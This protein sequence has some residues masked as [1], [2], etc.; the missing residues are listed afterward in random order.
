[1]TKIN[2]KCEEYHKNLLGDEFETFLEWVSREPKRSIRVNPLKT[3]IEDFSEELKNLNATPIPWCPTGFWVEG[4]GIGASIPHLFGYFYIQEAASM[5]PPLVLDVE[6]KDCVLDMCAAPGSKTTQMAPFCDTIIAN[7]PDISRSKAL[8]ANVERCGVMNA[9]ITHFDGL[10]FPQHEIF[11]KVL[12]DVPCSNMGSSRK[13]SHVLRTWT[14][15]FARNIS[16]LQKGLLR[17]AYGTLKSGGTLVYSTCTSSLE[18]NEEVVL[19]LLEKEDNAKLEVIDK[20]KLN[21]ETREGLLPGSENA[22]RIY[23]WDNNTEFFFVAK[24]KK[25]G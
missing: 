18:E 1:M 20:K 21:M 24:I 22:I 17:K 23:P 2:K 25:D 12:V 15:G 13:N 9:C 14:P 5:V 3:S 16:G 4:K 6:E 10:R 8:V 11:D 19:N 7:E